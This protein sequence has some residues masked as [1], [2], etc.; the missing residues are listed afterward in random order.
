MP[1][2]SFSP[3]TKIKSAEVNAN[4]TGVADATLWAA[5]VQAGWIQAGVTWTYASADAPTFTFTVSG[6]Y[7][8]IYQVGMRIRLKQGAG[9]LYFIVTALSYGAPNTT[10]T[11]Y[12]G[13]DYTLANSTITDNSY[14]TAKAPVGFP[15]S[16]AKWTQTLSDTSLRQQATPSASTWYNLG[17]L[18]INIPIGAWHVTYA[19]YFVQSK[20]NA[21]INLETALST[22]NNGATDTNLQ[23]HSVDVGTTGKDGQIAL[24]LGRTANLILAAKT[25]YYITSMTSVASANTMN[26]D[27][28][29]IPTLVTCVCNY[30]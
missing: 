26:L 28:S 6:D 27:G 5:A 2:T 4:F 21:S 23:T 15:L 29:V 13:T 7:T 22:T 11:V 20:T 18:S 16:P 8:S 14:S 12:G 25:T 10:V 30:L 17:S 9:Y 1:L 24:V 3:N 19:G